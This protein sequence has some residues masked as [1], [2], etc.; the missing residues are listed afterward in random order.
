MRLRHIEVF[1]AVMQ[2]GTISGAAQLLYISQPA[3]SKVL[4]HC[5]LQL[6][7]PLFE[8][9]KG[10]LYPTPEA[11]KL[12]LEVDKL[13]R[14]L[15]SV[16]RLASSLKLRQA[17][18]VRLVS[19]PTLAM[20]ILPA[21]ITSW[22]R[23][24]P[25]VHCKLGTQHTR[26]IVSE[27]LLGEADMALSLQDPQHPGIV[28]ESLASAPMTVIAPAGTWPPVQVGT[29]L[30]ITDLPRDLIA[31]PAD[32]P[33]GN[34]VADACAA[35][36]LALHAHTVV[37]TYQLARSL[38]ENGAGAAVIDPFTAATA[39]PARAQCRPLTPTIPVE[40]YLLTANAAPLSQSARY[41]VRCIRDAASSCL[42]AI[43]AG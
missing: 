34:R 24:F 1:H 26:E 28:A 3:V 43:K 23:K 38:V 18:H 41:L 22:R 30:A 27:L 42:Q 31:L 2:A 10:R 37:Q 12:F 7:F 32:D 25:D 8:R 4:Q 29:P 17:E 40:L 9:V 11:Q 14:D 35:H 33:L 21:A 6:G 15:Q 39:D 19:T 36:E 16:R 20:S 5:E 13:N